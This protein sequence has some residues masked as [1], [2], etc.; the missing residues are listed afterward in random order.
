MDN[1]ID[2]TYFR[3]RLQIANL[4]S[5]TDTDVKESLISLITDCQ[6]QFLNDILGPALYEQFVEW[7]E[8]ESEDEDDPFWGL[9]YGK[10]FDDE[11]E[12]TWSWI[13][14]ENEQKWSPLANFVY[15]EWQGNNF[16][17][18][19]SAGEVRSKSQNSYEAY[20]EQKMIDAWSGMVDWL[21][22]YGAYMDK[23]FGTTGTGD[24]AKYRRTF[25]CGNYSHKVNF[26][27]A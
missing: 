17:Q 3:N 8:S 9:L 12:K 4:Q 23:Y 10:I 26:L 1:L 5:T 18:T 13:G 22:A 11:N 16:T 25:Y 20:P 7:Y 24:W 19:T 21:R 15:Y 6:Y 14:L 2:E 27:D